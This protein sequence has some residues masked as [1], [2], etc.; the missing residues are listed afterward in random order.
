MTKEELKELTKKYPE[1][2]LIDL[3]GASIYLRK[4]DRATIKYAMSKQISLSGQSIDTISPGEVVLQKCIVGG[5]KDEVLT[6]DL[7]YFRAC[8]EAYKY[9]Q[10]V[11]GFLAVS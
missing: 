1:G 3:N 2:K 8:T 6:N 11:T 4:P 5:D 7:Y 9:V 10:Q